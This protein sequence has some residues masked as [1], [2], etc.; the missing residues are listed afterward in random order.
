MSRKQRIVRAGLLIAAVAAVTALGWLIGR[1]L[2]RF[3]SEPER[4]RLWIRETGFRGVAAFVLMNVLQ[5][6]AAVIPAGPFSVAAG[7]AFGPLWGTVICLLSNSAAAM[8]VFWLIRRFGGAVV[9]FLSGRE[10]EEFE[11]FRNKPRRE[12]L[13]LLIFLIPG[14]PKDVL[15]Y[16]AGLTDVSAP[17]FAGIN[18]VGRIPGILLSVLGG[19]SLMRGEYGLVLGVTLLA[20][21]LYLAGMFLYRKTIDKPKDKTEKEEK[22]SDK[23]KGEQP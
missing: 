4:F 8:G 12:L 6:F 11:L 3:V 7:Y 22:P 9:R 1:P 21:A 16:A 10:P 15:T 13:L 23:Q 19:E 14:S 18:L 20:A 5:V 17:A 2:V